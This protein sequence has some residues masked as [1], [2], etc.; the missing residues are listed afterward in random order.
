MT[1]YRLIPGNAL[2]IF[3]TRC[4]MAAM[5]GLLVAAGSAA[6]QSSLW[7]ANEN[8]PTLAE[9]QG[10]LKS[11]SDKPHGLISDVNDL[12]GS[13]T[14]AFDQNENLW[15]TNFNAN[16]I[17]EFAKS[18][19]QADSVNKHSH[20]AAVITISED[21]GE[22]LDGP[23]GIIFDS[24]QNMWIGAEDGQVILEYTPAQYAASGSPTPNVI[25]NAES[26]K[27]SSPSHL[28]FDAAGNLW[29]VD[30]NR[31]NDQ[32]GS[33]EVFR[34][35]QSQVA[36]LSA[37]KTLIRFLESRCRSLCTWKPL[38]STAAA[39]CGWRISKATAS[40]SFPRVNLWERDSLRISPLPWC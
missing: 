34:Y 40:T 4:V 36:G 1:H 6:A 18:E 35:N 16:S 33:G 29:V 28:A 14:I 39:I 20:P 9:F 32:G 13:S 15:V 22:N 37:V 23:E 25:L 5:A 8:S 30:E 21:A 11:G 27:F 12:D 31:D 19:W 7:I 10:A 24:A 26:F 17:T 2:A 38:R 3:R